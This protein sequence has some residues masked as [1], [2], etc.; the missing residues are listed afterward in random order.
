MK[1][2]KTKSLAEIRDS[3][4]FTLATARKDGGIENA[5]KLICQFVVDTAESLNMMSAVSESSIQAIAEDVYSVGYFLNIE[6][7]GF[8]FK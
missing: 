2:I 4:S 7:L 5:E 8:F 1:T 6:E 3:D